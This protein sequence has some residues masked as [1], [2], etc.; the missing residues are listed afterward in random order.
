MT[1]NQK[2]KLVTLFSGAGCFD[3]GFEVAGFKAVTAIDYDKDCCDTFQLNRKCN[4]IN[5]PIESISG[6]EF[7]KFSHLR[8]KELELLI[9]GPPC[10]PYS[11][12]SY[13]VLG[14]PLGFDDERAKTVKEYFRILEV[15][16]PKSFVIE[17][18]PQFISGKNERIKN[19]ITRKVGQ[20]NNKHGTN[21]KVSFCKINSAWY[22]IPQLRE[23]IFIIGSRDGH[24]FKMPEVRHLENG[25]PNL[26]IP[27]FRTSWDAIGHLSNFH[28]D[29]QTLKVGGKWGH[30]LESIPPG[31]NYLWHTKK[32]GGKKI[33]EWRSRYWNFLLK[34]HPLLPSWTIAANPGQN[35]GPFHWENRKLSTKELQ[36]LQTIPENYKFVGSLG[37]VRRQIGNGVPSAIGELI[38]KEIRRQLFGE[39]V[40][41]KNLQLIP[42]STPLTMRVRNKLLSV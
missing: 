41:S 28:H 11:K 4:I 1:N 3:L 42:A 19:Y 40:S 36:L 38:G 16:L 17:N 24:E 6:A 20:I 26:D 33:F 8:K 23:R 34:L 22:G 29:D 14:L 15:F 35:T 13:G 12:S 39:K 31:H 25:D 30:L 18:V 21:Y 32:G 9:G 2:P 7:L 5:A 27:P 37:S 10:Q